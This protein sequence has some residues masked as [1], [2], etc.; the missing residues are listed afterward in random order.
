MGIAR[1]QNE[2]DRKQQLR[3][4]L[5]KALEDEDLKRKISVTEES[6][7]TKKVVKSKNIKLSE[8]LVVKEEE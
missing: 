6:S 2:E 5:L 3:L 1:K 4:K 8:E 7:T